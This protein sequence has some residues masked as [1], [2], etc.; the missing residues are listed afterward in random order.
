MIVIVCSIVLLLL[1]SSGQIWRMIVELEVLLRLLM[2]MLIDVDVDVDVDFDF[3]FEG[4]LLLD[5]PVL[6]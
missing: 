4:P 1:I 3:D 6:V 2:L 5:S